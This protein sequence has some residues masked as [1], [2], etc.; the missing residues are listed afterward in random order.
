MPAT[1]DILAARY[2]APDSALT[3]PL[4]VYVSAA[5]IERDH[6]LSPIAAAFGVLW[7]DLPFKPDTR[8]FAVCDSC[9]A[10]VFPTLAAI[11]EIEQTTS[12]LSCPKHQ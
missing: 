6:L 4:A 2:P 3:S 8:V 9:N 7:R 1:R 11:R 10:P 12:W 5:D